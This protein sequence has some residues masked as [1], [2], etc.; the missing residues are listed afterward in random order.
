MS[1]EQTSR[2]STSTQTNS[3]A[4]EQLGMVDQNVGQD[5]QPESGTIREDDIRQ[6]SPVSERITDKNKEAPEEA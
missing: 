6:S 2:K 5:V 1:S 4:N 3:D